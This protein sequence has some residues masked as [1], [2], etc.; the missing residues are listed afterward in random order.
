MISF[1]NSKEDEESGKAPVGS[2]ELG[3]MILIC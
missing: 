2:L 1:Y 3:M